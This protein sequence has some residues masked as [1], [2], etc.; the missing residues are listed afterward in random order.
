MAQQNGRINTDLE[1]KL[2]TAYHDGAKWYLHVKAGEGDIA[3]LGTTTDADNETT[4]IGL[5][6]ALLNK[7]PEP[8]EGGGG[9]GGEVV[10]SG[11]LPAGTNKIGQVDIENMPSLTLADGQT[12]SIENMPP[13]TLTA[14]QTINIG[15]M[16]PI[17]L[18][19]GQT[20]GDGGGGGAAAPQGKALLYTMV[21]GELE[22]YAD[23]TTTID[24]GNYTRLL[25]K[26][27]IYGPMSIEFSQSDDGDY[28][29]VTDEKEIDF[30]DD[31]NVYPLFFNTFIHCRYL[32]V[33]FTPKDTVYDARI[34]LYGTNHN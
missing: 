2:T 10:I 9:S 5:L 8:V 30:D 27:D 14:G 12:I 6:K 16:P 11:P 3:A 26:I 29:T 33:T 20:I 7:A 22:A 21:E 4:V 15:S 25:G 31:G 23:V 17:T 13:L 19:D 24:M 28:W 18:A 1:G 34:G 32:K